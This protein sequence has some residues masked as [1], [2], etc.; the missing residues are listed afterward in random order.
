MRFGTNLPNK[1][2]GLHELA[3]SRARARY[4]SR[5]TVQAD[6]VAALGSRA[7]EKDALDD[8]ARWCHR[9]Y[10]TAGSFGIGSVTDAAEQ[11]SVTLQTKGPV[12]LIEQHAE[13]LASCMRNTL[14]T[15]R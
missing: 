15:D 11:L 6:E 3:I 2:E 12:K 1:A 13:W 7:S 5:L 10:G 14:S 4:Q 8:L 9:L